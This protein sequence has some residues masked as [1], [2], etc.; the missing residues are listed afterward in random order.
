M[1][2]WTLHLIDFQQQLVL[3]WL[4]GTWSRRMTP[5]TLANIQYNAKRRSGLAQGEKKK[6]KTDIHWSE[7]WQI[8]FLVNRQKETPCHFE[9]LHFISYI[10]QLTYCGAG[11]DVYPSAPCLH[12]WCTGFGWRKQC[13]S[14]WQV[15]GKRKWK[16]LTRRIRFSN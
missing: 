7:K 5:S 13:C 6:R 8:I 14:M 10:M 15:I 16:S 2:R 12:L 1:L 9:L 4:I 3:L 11:S